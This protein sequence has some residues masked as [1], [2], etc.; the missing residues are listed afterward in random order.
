MAENGN[1]KKGP[2]GVGVR[3]QETMRIGPFKVEAVAAQVRGETPMGGRDEGWGA[4][5]FVLYDWIPGLAMNFDWYQERTKDES[6]TIG[7]WAMSMAYDFDLLGGYPAGVEVDW[8]SGGDVMHVD[9]NVFS[10]RDWKL[11]WLLLVPAVNY[12]KDWW[13]R[14]RARRAGGDDGEIEIE[15]EE[16]DEGA[17]GMSGTDLAGMLQGMSGPDAQAMLQQLMQ[18]GGLQQLMG[19][20]MG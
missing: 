1:I 4:R 20:R 7:G 18:S 8:V 11:C 16:E 17:A 12:L 14:I 2:V 9:M 19:G 15:G 5:A 13:R 3:I 6:S 10:A